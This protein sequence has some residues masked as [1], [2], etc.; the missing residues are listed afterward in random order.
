MVAAASKA[1]D[2]AHKN[3]DVPEKQLLRD[4]VEQIPEVLNNIE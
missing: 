1:F 4:F 3:P 2:M